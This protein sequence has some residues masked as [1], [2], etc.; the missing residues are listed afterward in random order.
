MSARTRSAVVTSKMPSWP[1][2]FQPAISPRQSTVTVLEH[3]GLLEARDTR[4][5]VA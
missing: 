2:G 5:V 3:V 1:T 4:L